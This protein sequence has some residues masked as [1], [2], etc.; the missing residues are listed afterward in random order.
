MA[1]FDGLREKYKPNLGSFD[2]LLRTIIAVALLVLV[3]LRVIGGWLIVFPI[4]AAIYLI[5][6][7]DIGFSPLYRLLSWSTT[8]E[9]SPQGE[10]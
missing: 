8:K 2:R 5:L 6:T 7:G 1:V 10:K 4:V 9:E 3:F